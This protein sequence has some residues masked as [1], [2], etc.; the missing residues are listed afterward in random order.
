MPV[1]QT[2]AAFNATETPIV[3]ANEAKAELAARA[4]F[5]VPEEMFRRPSVTIC[6][7]WPHELESKPF[8]R[9]GK[10]RVIYRIAAGSPEKPSY[11]RVDNTYDMIQQQDGPQSIQQVAAPITGA[12]QAQNLVQYWVGDHPGNQAGRKGVGIINGDVATPEEIARLVKQQHNFLHFLVD[13]ADDYH[14]VGKSFKISGEH[15]RALEML[16]LDI[17]MHPWYTSIIQLYND[18]PECSE[19]I[20]NT[21][22]KCRYCSISLAQYFLDRDIEVDAAIW[23]N[24]PKEMEFQKKRAKNK[25]E[26]VGAF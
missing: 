7:I 26:Q 24:V 4:M 9:G 1:N 13:R 20:F 11:L 16:R 17:K 23:P 18:C 5:Q 3:L 25:K 15:K 12:H 6:S 21:A 14:R 19:K 10:G 8:S 22:T 2:I